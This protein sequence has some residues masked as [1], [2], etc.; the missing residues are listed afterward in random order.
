MSVTED[1]LG[2]KDLIVTN[3]AIEK[4][5]G[6]DMLV[7]S[8]KYADDL[9]PCCPKC[10]SLNSHRHA[11]REKDIRDI[12]ISGQHVI[13]RIDAINY[14][15]QDC[16]A[17]FTKETKMVD[18]GDRITKR[19][20]T[21]LGEKSIETT[22]EKIGR[23][24]HLSHTTIS[25]AFRDW[26]K[27]QDS[28]HDK[29]IYAPR[30]LGID[31]NHLADEP[32]GVFVDVTNAKLL[33]IV[34]DRYKSTIMDWLREMK[35]PDELEIV[36]IDMWA[37]YRD[38]VKEVFHGR[39]RVVVD[40][41]HVIQE[42][43]KQ[44]QKCRNNITADLPNG[45]LKPY[46]NYI[47]LLKMNLEDLTDE[48]K[49]RLGAFLNEFP[50][51][52]TAYALKESFRAI[53]RCTNRQD[54]EDGF[55]SWM[56]QIPEDKKF[57]PFRSVADTVN[58]WRTEIFNYFEEPITNAVTETMNGIIKKINRDGNGYSYEVLRA[59]AL[60][61]H[62][63]DAYTSV[64]VGGTSCS[65]TTSYAFDMVFFGQDKS[66]KRPSY[67]GNRN[68]YEHHFGVDIEQMKEEVFGGIFFKKEDDDQ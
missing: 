8:C 49:K 47:S 50:D 39:V 18:P 41:Y 28:K 59:K 67:S 55:D 36:T 1:I 19:F 27:K 2:L 6:V 53:Y 61:S 21:F 10:G 15:C 7:I 12:D 52:R 37:P 5:D 33:D 62:G 22:F 32:R 11:H 30:I 29:S 60:Y 63:N 54:A 58:N 40:H 38:A 44:F 4:I 26:V 46:K 64:C 14:L 56:E 35:N 65:Y 66:K 9:R 25:N 31:E 24:Y 23:D 13:L 43:Q 51:I 16:G 45:S 17:T 34:K 20:K 3:R 42:L 68:I 48:Q 57:N